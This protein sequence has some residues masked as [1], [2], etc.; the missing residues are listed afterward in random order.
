MVAVFKLQ[1]A[2]SAV[3]VARRSLHRHWAEETLQGAGASVEVLPGDSN[4]AEVAPT[5]EIA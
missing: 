5:P 1:C 2:P 3:K 4:T